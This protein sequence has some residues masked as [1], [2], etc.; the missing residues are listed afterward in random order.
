[1]DYATYVV[2]TKDRV[3]THRKLE[4]NMGRIKKFL[5]SN[6][7]VMNQAK[8][9]LTEIM[10]KQKRQRLRCEAPRLDAVNRMGEHKR[11]SCS[12]INTL[13]GYNFQEYAMRQDHLETGKDAVLP[14]LRKR[15]GGWYTWQDR[16]QRGA[17]FK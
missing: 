8:T 6:K 13:L 10:T 15:L 2:T 7:L 17:Y 5:N 3:T 12:R 14:A 1:M 9:T 11:I 16:F 4:E